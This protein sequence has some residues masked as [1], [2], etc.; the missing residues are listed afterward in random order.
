MRL[1]ALFAVLVGINVY[2]FFFRGGTSIHDVLKTSA[3]SKGSV[4]T[5]SKP[6]EGRKA[7]ARQAPQARADDSI[8]VEGGLKG[9][10]GLSGALAMLKIDG[11]QISELIAALRPELDM[12]SLRPHQ[13][14]EARLDPATKRFRKFSFRLSPISAVVVKR[15]AQGVLKAARMEEKLETR[16]VQVGG[17]V[18]SSLNGAMTRAGESSALVA[19]FV[20]L[21][22]WDINWYSDPRE[23]DEFRI[24]V[25][26]K[27][28]RGELRSSRPSGT[29]RRSSRPYRGAPGCSGSARDEA[30]QFYRYG[31]ILAAEYRGKVGRF[32]AY[33][34]RPQGGKG[35]HY[36]PEG[37]SIY[38]EFL[39]MPLHYR[40][41]S[42]KFD[43]RRFHPVLHRTKGHFGVDY[44][45]ARGTPVWTVADGK[46]TRLG[47]FGGAGNMIMLQH[48]RGRTTLYMHLS[49]FA[50]GLRRDSK[51]KQRQVIG[52]VGSTGLATGPHLHYGIQ[53]NG[54]HVDPLKF[55][56]NK[57]ALLPRLQRIR[58]LDDLS[59]RMAAL[60]SIPVKDE[61]ES[62]LAR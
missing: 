28:R 5:K 53:V 2:V 14:F 25:E 45:A 18:R 58:F 47:R 12:R 24:V 19:A 43:R 8:I 11:A 46:V 29:A 32:Q 49:R 55:G 13:T 59:P 44:A 17:R 42:S 56:S 21:F 23:G 27:Y 34:F 4:S 39:K 15:N 35:G 51:V 57:G 22:S 38:R 33:Y 7:P 50:R 16:V 54:R 52:Y 31:H 10:V 62:A 41:I 6:R 61:G 40:R 20:D 9:H 30:T 3:L 36:T 37:R 60:E 48:A 1:G 26:K